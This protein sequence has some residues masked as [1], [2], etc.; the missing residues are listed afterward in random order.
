[1]LFA[2]LKG[3]YQMSELQTTCKK[4]LLS[5]SYVRNVYSTGRNSCYIASSSLQNRLCSSVNDPFFTPFKTY[6]EENK[7]S[8]S[9]I[10]NYL[11]RKNKLPKNKLPSKPSPDFSTIRITDL[12]NAPLP[13]LGLGFAGLLPFSF[14]PLVS[15]LYHY[16]PFLANCQ[17]VYGA[18]ILSF[19]G[20]VKW[21]YLLPG[22]RE[23]TSWWNYSLS[24]L[25]SLIASVALIIPQLFGFIV[26]IAGLLGAFFVDLTYSYYPPWFI[27][28]RAIL[29][30]TA[31]FF[32]LISL[33]QSLFSNIKWKY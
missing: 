29:T 2:A 20:G 9:N 14:P 17:L 7:Q 15:V 25:P 13:V 6:H 30:F 31:V 18:A 32:L 22:P 27:S 23:N 4:F 10:L 28:L 11:R 8:H 5:H 33:I 19:L 12:R 26:I 21:G 3:P 24:V 1:M 16:S